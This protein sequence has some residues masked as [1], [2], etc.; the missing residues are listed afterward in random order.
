MFKDKS[1]DEA[2]RC[3]ALSHSEMMARSALRTGWSCMEDADKRSELLFGFIVFRRRKDKSA[4]PFNT[5]LRILLFTPRARWFGTRPGTLISALSVRTDGLSSSP[6]RTQLPTA[7]FLLSVAADS[8]LIKQNK[9][10]KWPKVQSSVHTDTNVF[11]FIYSFIHVLVT[12]QLQQRN[13]IK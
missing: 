10:T 6:P 1:R 11:L 5:S 2:P 8:W 13:N 9:T 3:S 7:G 4:R 12:V